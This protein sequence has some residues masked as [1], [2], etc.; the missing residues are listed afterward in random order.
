MRHAAALVALLVLIGSGTA[1][2]YDA[3]THRELA[4]KAASAEVSKLDQILRREL[5]LT[6]GIRKDFPGLTMATPRRVEQL[7][8]DGALSE[9]VPPHRSLNHFHNPLIDPWDNAGLRAFSIFGM[10]TVRGQSSALWQ[11][12]EEQDTSTVF[13][14]PLPLASGGGN[15]SWQDARQRYLAALTRPRKEDTETEPGRDRAFGELF[16]NLGHLAHLVQDAF[17]PAHARNDAHPPGVRPDSYERWVQETRRDRPGLFTTLLSATPK[18]PNL[19][20]FTSTGNTLAPVPVARLI[21]TDTFSPLNAGVLGDENSLIGAAEYTNGNFLSRGTLFRSFTLPRPGALDA[22]PIVEENPGQFRRYFTKSREGATIAH[23]VAEGLLFDS[24]AVAQAVPVPSTGWMLDDRVHEDYAGVLLPRA[25]GYSAALL[26]YFFRGRL[27][28]EL[29]PGDGDASQAKLVGVNRSDDALGATGQ[30]TLYWEDAAGQRQPVEG[31]V[32]TLGAPVEK[33]RP[34]PELTFPWPSDP[35]RPPKRFVLAYQGPLGLEANAVV[36]KVVESPALEQAYQTALFDENTQQ[37]VFPWFLR[38]AE[39]IYVLPF[40][41][42]LPGQF[43]NDLRWGEKDNMLVIQA[44]QGDDVF[45]G[46]T[47]V[48][49]EIDRAEGV[50]AVP[51]TGEIRYGH[52]VVALHQ[53]RAVPL[54]ALAGLDLGTTVDLSHRHILRQFLLSFTVTTAYRWDDTVP[55]YVFDGGTVSDGS[56]QLATTFDSTYAQSFRLVT[57]AAHFGENCFDFPC[58]HYEWFWEDFALTAAGEVLLLVVLREGGLPGAQQ[59]VPAWGH[60]GSGDQIG[61]VGND[62]GLAFSFPDDSPSPND[63]QKLRFVAWVNLSQR[64]VAAKTMSDRVTLGQVTVQDALREERQDI[65]EK[66]GGPDAGTTKFDWMRIFSSPCMD[67]ANVEATAEIQLEEGLV[68]LAYTGLYRG[69]FAPL[70]LETDFVL[71]PSATVTK[72]CGAPKAYQLTRIAHQLAAFPY[73]ITNFGFLTQSVLPGAQALERF[74]LVFTRR[75]GE[76]SQLVLWDGLKGTAQRLF[77]VAAPDA[78]EAPTANQRWALV[79]GY[80]MVHLV[81]LDGSGTLDLPWEDEFGRRFTDMFTLVA[82]DRLY[83]ALEDT[84]YTVVGQALKPTKFRPDPLAAAAFANV[85]FW[86]FHLVRPR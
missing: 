23:F 78:F 50:R 65:T 69:E 57:D 46:T 14:F 66:S 31:P 59:G 48:V 74:P 35:E 81:A 37:F 12:N 28:F 29:L 49:F 79:E 51:T 25:V 84:F 75:S 6:D 56:P 27:D 60:V 40:E 54:T 77:Q 71:G 39:G 15:W 43:L 52:P 80:P 70:G 24:L 33:H 45:T 85:P 64:T 83:N 63:R 26:D 19:A 68:S 58:P 76:G 32:L 62:L 21:D 16:E 41:D 3:Q 86:P 17:V 73:L 38:T 36:G 42:S 34:L 67:P 2:A 10:S 18:L 7:I 53:L 9:D 20:I 1:I 47:F 4:T 44:N 22:G 30:L 5:G 11:Q 82:P 72:R 55:A 13:V 61:P 8:G